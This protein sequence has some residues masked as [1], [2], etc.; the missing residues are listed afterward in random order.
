MIF[1]HHLGYQSHYVVTNRNGEI[2]QMNGSPDESYDEF[3]I[4]QPYLALP[5]ALIELI[6]GSFEDLIANWNRP[7]PEHTSNESSEGIIKK[8]PS[9]GLSKKSELQ[10]PQPVQKSNS[11]GLSKKF[12]LPKIEIQGLSKK[13]EVQ[14]GQPIKKSTSGGI[15]PKKAEV[16]DGPPMKKSTSGG[17]LPKK[18]EYPKNEV[19]EAAPLKKSLSGGIVKKVD[20]TDF[21]ITK[22]K[23]SLS[24][25]GVSF[26]TSPTET[27]LLSESPPPQVRHNVVRGYNT[28]SI[29]EW[30]IGDVCEW[31]AVLRPEYD[32]AVFRKEQ[33]DGKALLTLSFQDIREDLQVPLGVAKI[34][35]N[36][37]EKIN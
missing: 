5:V 9:G 16:Q 18:G 15:L 7:I 27:M 23:K 21:P 31:I 6:P 3:V 8:V 19:Q 14:E 17:T 28:K 10:E 2:S 1:I 22:K 29:S 11:G 35:M 13:V 4:G 34:L 20:G 32:S 26:S 37:L 30:S 12:E 24:T 36:E 25:N 33:I